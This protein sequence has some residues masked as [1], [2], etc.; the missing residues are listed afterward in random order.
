MI[1]RR[2]KDRLTGRIAGRVALAA[3]ASAAVGLAILVVGVQVVGADIFRQLMVTHGSAA[4]EAQAMFDASVTVVVAIAA[5]MAVLASI[6]LAM[7][8]ASMLAQPLE[9]M[10]AAARRVAAGDY[11]ARVPREGPEELVSLADSFNQ[12][13]ARLAEQER[14]R[15]DFIANA[16]HELRTPLTNLQGYL[17]ALRDGVISADSATYASLLDEADRLVRLSRSLDTLAEGDST[18]VPPFLEEVDLAAAIRAALE[19]AQPTLERAGLRLEAD[20]PATLAA[21]ANP[22]H[23]AQVLNNLMSNAIRY[24]SPGGSVAV[25]AERRS[26]D[27]L[28]SI[29]NT[30]DQIPADDVPRLFERFYRVE[31]SRDRARGGAGIGLAIV[32]QLVEAAGGRV[33]AESGGG[34]TRFWFSLPG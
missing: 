5:T 14:I 25:R 17:E 27:I 13:A 8:L 10:G 9:R 6:G 1:G 7:A 16:A 32:K 23:L 2:L 29:A 22:D 33:G 28:V 20:V 30:G 15:R 19:L 31:K 21:R 3:V 18:T 4:D 11:A 34:T 12:M 24:S 26:A